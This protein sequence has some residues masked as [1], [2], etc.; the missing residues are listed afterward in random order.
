MPD[1]PGSARFLTEE[2]QTHAVERFKTRD[3]TAK[4]SIHWKQF[5][6]GVT[7]YRN[8]LHTMIHFMCNF[9]FAGLS[10]FLPTIVE[11][12]GFESVNAQGLTAQVYF[13]SFLCCVADALVSDRWGKRGFVIIFAASIGCVGY[14]LL[15]ALEHERYNNV[16]YFAVWLAVCGV[17]P[18]LCVNVSTFPSQQR[19]RR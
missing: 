4:N 2:Q 6:A 10:N 7:D 15:A 19:Y 5:M 11:G 13:T 16:R 12:M 1:S 18:A 8:I 14:L 17:F 3:R 9:S